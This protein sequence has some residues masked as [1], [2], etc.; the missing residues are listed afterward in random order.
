MA[1]II[2]MHEEYRAELIAFKENPEPE[3][4]AAHG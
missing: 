2:I 4:G 3:Q 1:E